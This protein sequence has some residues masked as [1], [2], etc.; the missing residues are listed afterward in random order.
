VVEPE[1]QVF[2]AGSGLAVHLAE[3]WKVLFHGITAGRGAVEADAMGGGVVVVF[4][5]PVGPGVFKVGP[6]FGAVVVAPAHEVVESQGSHV[7]YGGLPGAHHDIQCGCRKGFA[8]GEG[9][10][11]P[12]PADLLRGELV[13]PGQATKG[14]PVGLCKVM[15]APVG[16]APDVGYPGDGG[17]RVWKKGSVCHPR[18]RGARTL[19]PGVAVKTLL[20]QGSQVHQVVGESEVLLGDLKFYH[21][22]CFLHGAKKGTERLPGLK[23]YGSVFDLNDHILCKLPVEGHEFIVSLAMPVLTGGIVN[24]RPP[25]DHSV[26]RLQGLGQHVGPVGMGAPVILG[27]RLALGIGLHQEP[28][29]I[30][31]RRIDLPGFLPPP[32]GDLRLKGIRVGKPAN[33][34]RRTEVH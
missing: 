15:A 19:A 13:V 5:E 20:L 12:F 33:H 28:P 11:Q 17:Q 30:G 31:N 32:C 34:R 24:E 27:P 4:R 14:I 25:H 9:H 16:V 18:D 8:A 1:E 22:G 3:R 6:G 29:E 26:V 21:E 2:G 10:P 23:V 7:F